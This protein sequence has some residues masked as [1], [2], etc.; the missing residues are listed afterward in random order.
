MSILFN[1]VLISVIVLCVLC[2]LKLNVLMA[3]T[4]AAMTGAILAHIPIGEAME[5]LCSGF[6]AN[7]AT[8]L[9]YIFLGTF[10]T[11]VASSG[12]ADI[13]SK[14]LSRIMGKSAT[15]LL[16]IL[17]AFAVA[18]TVWLYVFPKKKK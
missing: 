6:S 3:L 17:A 7:A 13:M 15:K 14:K 9:A 5:I 1:P 12:F 8:A 18:L 2:L 11:A 4:L 10:V 16:L